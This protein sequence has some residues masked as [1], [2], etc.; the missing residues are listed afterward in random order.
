MIS[1]A[2]KFQFPGISKGRLWCT[3]AL[4]CDRPKCM[5]CADRKRR[6]RL[7]RLF[8]ALVPVVRGQVPKTRLIALHELGPSIT[9]LEEDADLAAIFDASTYAKN[10]ANRMKLYPDRIVTGL[11]ITVWPKREED[12]WALGWHS[13]FGAPTG[14]IRDRLPLD[15]ASGAAQS[16]GPAK[17]CRISYVRSVPVL[18]DRLTAIFNICATV[19]VGQ[20]VKPVASE[21]NRDDAEQLEC[22]L[23]RIP[24]DRRVG[25][26]ARG[27]AVPKPNQRH[28]H[29]LN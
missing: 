25:V 24:E 7:G 12:R 19:R 29:G 18:L 2:A 9:S 22:V 3:T 4:P 23:E 20:T 11:E 10:L 13:L 27:G 8:K 14:I 16:S 28:G 26:V 6:E 15:F 5:F 1:P 17:I 21:L